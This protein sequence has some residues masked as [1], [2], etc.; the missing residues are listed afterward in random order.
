MLWIIENVEEGELAGDKMLGLKWSLGCLW[1]G[2][3]CYGN[4]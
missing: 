2:I 1:K 4:L 3:I